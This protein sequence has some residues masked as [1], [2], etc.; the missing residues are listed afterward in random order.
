MHCI[1]DSQAFSDCCVM[2]KHSA[3]AFL[4]SQCVTDRQKHVICSTCRFSPPGSSLDIAAPFERFASAQEASDLSSPEVVHLVS[5]HHIAYRSYSA[6]RF[7]T[8]NHEQLG[9][10]GHQQLEDELIVSHGVVGCK[11]A[12]FHGSSNSFSYSLEERKR[13]KK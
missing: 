4:Q 12:H 5:C 11:R 2:L 6:F 13:R 8:K 1:S 3:V 10:L 7:M 9:C